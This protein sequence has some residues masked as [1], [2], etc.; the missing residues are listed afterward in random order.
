MDTYEQKYLKYKSKYSKLKKSAIFSDDIIGGNNDNGIYNLNTLVIYPQKAFIIKNVDNDTEL[1]PG[2]VE[3]S[4]MFHRLDGTISSASVMTNNN[5]LQQQLQKNADVTVELTNGPNIIGKI[6]NIDTNGISLVGS[7]GKFYLVKKWN[8]VIFPSVTSD[9]PMFHGKGDGVL[10]YV[11]DTIGWTPLYNLYIGSNDKNR[12][13][14]QL[15]ASIN[16]TTGLNISAENIMLVAGNLKMENTNK[17]IAYRM[18]KSALPQAMA[19]NTPA[20]E[21]AELDEL[22]T[23]N[24]PEKNIVGNRFNVP[25]F[26]FEFEPHNV[27]II[28]MGKYH[29]DIPYITANYG[30][31]IPTVNRDLPQGLV[32]VFSGSRDDIN[33]LLGSVQV[34]R[35]PKNTSMEIILGE[36]TRIR[37]NVKKDEV[38]TKKE[39]N[40]KSYHQKKVSIF[41]AIIN[42]TNIVQKVFIREW[43]GTAKVINPNVQYQQKMGYIEW[44]I[45]AK[46]GSTKFELVYDLIF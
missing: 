14:I 35:T 44:P 36:T 27:Y 4:V 40:N 6:N 17:M 7:D 24:L 10:K 46:P 15:L 41:G 37:S 34:P 21:F 13:V 20:N 9:K 22:Q 30:Y 18:E 29:D 12:G 39:K 28:E 26:N 23:F 31:V 42:D 3:D 11:V 25:L 2:F 33:M 43:V 45:N 16:N 8:N 5:I 1:L 19:Y 38:E 32:R